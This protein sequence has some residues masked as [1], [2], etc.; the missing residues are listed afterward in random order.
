MRHTAALYLLFAHTCAAQFFIQASDPQFGMFTEN[1]DFRQET[2]NW[3]FV[4]ANVNRLKPGFLVVTGDLT[5][6]EGNRAQIAEYQR[7]NRTLDPAIHLYNVPGNHDVGNEP[8]PETLAAYG[9]SY[10]PDFYSFRDA[11]VYGIVLNSSLF[12]SPRHAP[13]EAAKQERW[14]EEELAKAQASGLVT[15]KYVFAGHYHRNASGKD[16]DLDMITTGPAGKPLGT[17]PSG[18]RIAEIREGIISQNY[19]SLG[20]IP[21]I[22][23]VPV[24]KK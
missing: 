24:P 1:C 17:D 9:R 21:N 13:E 5:N 8:T 16:G 20:A 6:Q 11:G 7:I 14:L 4:I 3:E 19:Y 23:P 10:G 18:L 2:A 15:V 22:F 12:K